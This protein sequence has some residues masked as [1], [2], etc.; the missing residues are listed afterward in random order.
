M[1]EAV[2]DPKE[3]LAA[4]FQRVY[5]PEADPIEVALAKAAGDPLVA[6]VFARVGAARLGLLRDIF[7]ELGLDAAEADSRAWL[8]WGFYVGHHQLQ[9]PA[10]PERLDRIVHLLVRD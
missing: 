1:A 9:S 2:A 6:P 7:L 3:R 10:K 8:A 4:L 5:E